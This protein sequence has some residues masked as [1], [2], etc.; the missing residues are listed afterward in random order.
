MAWKVEFMRFQS[1]RR[2]GATKLAGSLSLGLNCEMAMSRSP[3]GNGKG[4]SRIASIAEK[5]ALFAPMPSAKVKITAREND[6]DLR[7]NRSADFRLAMEA[8]TTRTRYTS[9]SSSL[10]CSRPPNSNMAWRRAS[11][12]DIPAAMF[13]SFFSSSRRRHTRFDCDWSSDVCSSDLH[14]PIARYYT[15]DEFAALRRHGL[16]MGY[17]HVEAGP[18]VRSSYHAWEQ[19]ERATATR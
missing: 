7:I 6:G 18:L 10:I 16:E 4:R 14:L 9:R 13:S 8:S 19:V 2:T 1:S 3:F 11:C 17:R 12:A 5:T 15:P